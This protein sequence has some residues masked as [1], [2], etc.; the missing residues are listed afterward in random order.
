[1]IG[2]VSH[3]SEPVWSRDSDKCLALSWLPDQPHCL[4]AASGIKVP[5]PPSAI[6]FVFSSYMAT[7]PPHPSHIPADNQAV[8]HPGQSRGPRKQR[9]SHNQLRQH[10]RNPPPPP[11]HPPLPSSSSTSSSPRS[12]RSQSL[13][14]ARCSRA[15]SPAAATTASSKFG[16]WPCLPSPSSPLPQLQRPSQT[17]HFTLNAEVRLLHPTFLYCELFLNALLGLLFASLRAEQ[18]VEVFDFSLA[19]MPGSEHIP[20]TPWRSYEL[21]EE[22][23]RLV[24]IL[25]H[26]LCSISRTRL[27]THSHLSPFRLPRHAGNPCPMSLLP[28]FYFP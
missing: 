21:P 1:V 6:V 27:G 4:A 9:S 24:T 10:P 2:D 19:P 11:R 16:T 28:A 5:P 7:L 26:L 17:Y 25:F 23:C 20:V 13:P 3:I 22:V 12:F 8:R 15:G 18:R 14:C